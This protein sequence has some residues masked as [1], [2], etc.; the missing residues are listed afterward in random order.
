VVT[1]R[2]P[3]R[4]STISHQAAVHPKFTLG[5][6]TIKEEEE[7]EEEALYFVLLPCICLK[8]HKFTQ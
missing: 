2:I 3:Y 7:E 8:I 5:A 1:V 4:V 6:L